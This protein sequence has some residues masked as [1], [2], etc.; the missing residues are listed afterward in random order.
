MSCRTGPLRVARP[1]RGVYT[2]LAVMI[3][4][5]L[6]LVGRKIIPTNG[7]AMRAYFTETS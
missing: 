2:G 4:L 6:S 3:F 1:L 7:R 5:V